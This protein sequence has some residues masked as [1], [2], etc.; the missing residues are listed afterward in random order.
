[1][2]VLGLGAPGRGIITI[3]YA[4]EFLNKDQSA[5]LIPL[6]NI[7]AGTIVVLMSF[8]Y[9]VISNNTKYI[10]IVFLFLLTLFTFI[11]VFAAPESPK[12]LVSK[13]RFREAKESLE[14]VARFN[15]QTISKD[16][17]LLDSED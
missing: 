3:V 1:M 9:Q 7:W 11:T 15:G 13:G 17:F 8:Y 16:D 5:I 14:C 2:F 6:C 4:D 12:W 10:Q